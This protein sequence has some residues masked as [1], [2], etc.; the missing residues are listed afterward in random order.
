MYVSGDSYSRNPEITS[1]HRPLGGSSAS[2]RV[3]LFALRRRRQVHLAGCGRGLG[4]VPEET[5][6]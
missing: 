4:G 2:R 5:V 1:F 3:P 6:A